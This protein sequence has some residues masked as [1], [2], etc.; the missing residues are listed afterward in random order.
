MRERLGWALLLH[1]EYHLTCL[2]RAD[3]VQQCLRSL[4]FITKSGLN[5]LMRTFGGKCPAFRFYFLLHLLVRKDM[6]SSKIKYD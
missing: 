6:F 3:R 4:D 5:S 1:T 2:E